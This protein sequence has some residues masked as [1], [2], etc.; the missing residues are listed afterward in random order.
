M[1]INILPIKGSPLPTVKY[2]IDP[3][4]HWELI[5][6]NGIDTNQKPIGISYDF[7]SMRS[8]RPN[9]NNR[10]FH[11]IYATA[12]EDEVSNTLLKMIQD[13]IKKSIKPPNTDYEPLCLVIR[14]REKENDGTHEHSH[15]H[16][17]VSRI[18]PDGA[19]IDDSFIGLR[20]L[21]LSQALEKKYNLKRA[22]DFENKRKKELK[23]L[24]K[25]VTINNRISLEALNGKLSSID[26]KATRTHN[27]GGTFINIF[28]KK[29]PL[30][31]SFHESTWKEEQNV[32]EEKTIVLNTNKGGRKVAVNRK[33]DKDI[34]HQN[35]NSKSNGIER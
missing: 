13:E 2:L 26:Y 15:C 33:M 24:L 5:D 16:M 14:H 8:L 9:I 17:V 34:N 30:K 31:F 1:V 20:L 10:Y 6:S 11:I 12:E 35:K 23:A 4:K 18:L 28:H 22:K 32:I 19:L 3:T 29:S 27:A 7:E 21:L 25:E